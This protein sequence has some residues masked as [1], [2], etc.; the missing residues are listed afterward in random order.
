M[1]NPIE[2]ATF[3]EIS[4]TTRTYYLTLSRR[5][6]RLYAKLIIGSTFV[7]N[8]AKEVM[9]PKSIRIPEK[10]LSGLREV[11]EEWETAGWTF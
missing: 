7:D 3:S 2:A 9:I 6:F 4:T 1:V 10:Y 5:S 8:K 11:L